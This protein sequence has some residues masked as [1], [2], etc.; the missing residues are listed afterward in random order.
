MKTP[1]G[2][3]TAAL[4]SARERVDPNAATLQQVDRFIERLERTQFDAIRMYAV[5]PH[6]P[7]ARND[8]R[9]RAQIAADH[10]GRTDLRLEVAGAIETFLAR[11]F[12]G[13][14][15]GGIES[16]EPMRP[17][18]RARLR[19]TLVDA[20]LAVVAQDVIDERTFNQLVG[21]CSQLVR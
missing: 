4:G 10:A 20:S 16:I 13:R 18:D 11:A 6:A 14:P 19:T 2:R 12:D 9:R 3:L 5:R 15:L 7:A 1:L 8:A 17:E 21:P